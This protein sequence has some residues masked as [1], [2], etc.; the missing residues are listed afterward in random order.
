M[1]F[2]AGA[3]FDSVAPGSYPPDHLQVHEWREGHPPLASQLFENR[4]LFTRAA[5]NFPLCKSVIGDLRLALTENPSVDIEAEIE[6]MFAHSERYDPLR[7]GLAALRFYLQMILRQCEKIWLDGARGIT[8]YRALL[9]RLD[10]WRLENDEK[11]CLVT[12]NYDTLLESALGAVP[13][14]AFNDL[15]DYVSGESGYYVIK[16]HGSVNWG[17]RVSGFRPEGNQYAV[18][19]A[20]CRGV[21][22]FPLSDEREMLTDSMPDVVH[23]EGSTRYALMPAIAIPT[24]TKNTFECPPEHVERLQECIR[25]TDR[26]L[27]I[28]WRGTEKNFLAR[29][30]DNHPAKMVVQIAAGS[31]D[32]ARL[33]EHNLV[34]SGLAPREF[35]ITGT[36]FTQFLSARKIDE[37]I[38]PEKWTVAPYTAES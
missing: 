25:E 7:I 12:F 18:A 36:G 20:L 10:R 15:P 5:N 31:A 29:W 22:A 32:S 14:V 34:D 13:G 33:V 1:V 4:D 21:G 30:K 3:S 28:G 35:L 2:G 8:N 6:Q 16:P 38:A 9:H 17:R 27:I 24:Q 26:L 11:I 23:S 19:E 37:L